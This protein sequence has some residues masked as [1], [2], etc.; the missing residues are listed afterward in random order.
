MPIER[1]HLGQIRRTSTF[2]LTALL[3]LVFAVGV[4]ALLGLIYGLSARELTLR[5]DRVLRIEASRLRASSPDALPERIASALAHST[6]GLNYFALQSR[7][8]QPIVGNLNIVRNFRFDHPV[9]IAAK[10]GAH[11][12]LRVL[13]IEAPTGETILIA[14][15]IAPIVDLRRRIL[16][17]L[18]GSG[19][20]IVVLVL[21]AGVLLS[22][23]PL[24]RVRDLQAVSRAIAAGRFDLRMPVT[25]RGDELDLFAGTVNTMIEEVE[26]VV[27]QVK[28][29]TDAVAHDLR[30]P[31]AHVRGQLERAIAL[32]DADPRAVALSHAAMVDLDLVL[33]RF[34]ALLRISQLEASGRQAGFTT[35]PLAPLLDSLCEL[36]EPLAE[37]AG[38]TLRLAPI[39][40]ATIRCDPQLLFEAISNLLDNAI[41]FSPVGGEVVLGATLDPGG[42]SLTVRDT[43]RGLAPHE[44]DAALRRFYRGVDAAGIPGSGLGLSIV[45]AIAHLHG[46]TLELGDAAPGLIVRIQAPA[47][48]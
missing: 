10:P 48:S 32:P 5:S 27:A 8:G 20:A 30:T 19:I 34:G 4:I 13:A 6:S 38:V 23:A 14:R 26:R 41:K 35:V 46:F 18:I 45:A 21:G 7:S 9:N 37:D 29:V 39:P 17:I 16:E 12:P 33:E 42:L 2:R 44:R 11:G 1:L 47:A 31:L 22:L 3:G 36:Y 43:G 25:T 24:R 40:D 15:D 28:G